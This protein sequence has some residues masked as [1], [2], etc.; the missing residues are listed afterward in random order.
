MA[1]RFSWQL[2]G[3]TR[4]RTREV[5]VTRSAIA[6]GDGIMAYL[7]AASRHR[8]ESPKRTIIAPVDSATVHV[9]VCRRLHRCETEAFMCHQY[10]ESRLLP[11]S[12][13][14]C[15]SQRGLRS[16]KCNSSSSAAIAIHWGMKINMIY[17]S[18][19][20]NYRSI[21]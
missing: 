18:R 20:P 9:V 2:H 3:Y 19:I 6:Q 21:L 12:G 10:V 17:H 11:K 16:Q 13:R 8:Q 15:D 4:A 5:Q 7:T 14:G 1:R